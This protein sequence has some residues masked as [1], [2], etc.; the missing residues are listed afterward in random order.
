LSEVDGIAVHASGL[1]EE[2]FAEDKAPGGLMV[3]F[4][5]RH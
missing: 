4:T 3:T 2:G 1:V 5:V